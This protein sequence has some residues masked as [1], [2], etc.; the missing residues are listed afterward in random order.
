MSCRSLGKCSR[1]AMGVMQKGGEFT[2]KVVG[3][4]V[5]GVAGCQRAMQKDSG[6]ADQGRKLRSYFLAFFRIHANRT[7]GT[8]S[9]EKAVSLIVRNVSRQSESHRT[10]PE[11][12]S[13]KKCESCHAVR[14]VLYRVLACRLAVPR[15]GLGESART[16]RSHPVRTSDN[17]CL[18]I[19][20]LQEWHVCENVIQS[21]VQCHW[22]RH[23]PW[24]ESPIT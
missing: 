2:L 10:V 16:W 4:R 11:K 20:R 23:T 17:F 15:S 12:G 7:G 5:S 6:R 1:S 13:Q 21:E 22:I 24:C 18:V 9:T 19:S 3:S 14:K 8:I